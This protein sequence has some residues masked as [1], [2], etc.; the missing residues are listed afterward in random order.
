M[1]SLGAYSSPPK[2]DR[3]DA[4]AKMNK[5]LDAYVIKGVK[6]NIPLL[7]DII[8]QE[9]FVK[10]DLTTSFIEEVYPEGFK[11][12]E[13]SAA[14][15]DQLVAMSV[16]VFT[17]RQLQ[18]QRYTNQ[19]N[20]PSSLFYAGELVATVGG[21]EIHASVDLTSANSIDVTIDGRVVPIEANWT[22][23]TPIFEAEIAGA[24]VIGQYLGRKGSTFQ[25]RLCGSEVCCFREIKH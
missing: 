15:K 11:G 17:M 16:Y 9:R 14:E 5:A 1:W 20:S 19:T 24:E 21:E 25:L 4:L 18:N 3:A 13:L 22:L 8:N 2:Q 12:Y 6:H 7:R 23:G 10:G